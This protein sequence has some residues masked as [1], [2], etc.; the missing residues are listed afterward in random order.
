MHFIKKSLFS[1]EWRSLGLNSS[2]SPTLRWALT[3]PP[4]SSR[5][6]FIWVWSPPTPAVRTAP[7]RSQWQTKPQK[8]PT[9]P[10]RRR[11]GQGSFAPLLWSTEAGFSTLGGR[12]ASHLRRTRGFPWRACW[13]TSLSQTSRVALRRRSAGT[14]R[15]PQLAFEHTDMSLVKCGLNEDSKLTF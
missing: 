3:S 4:G 10:C 9:S 7:W 1:L 5:T 14:R 2:L 6:Q 12:K 8:N 15:T 13:P 11:L